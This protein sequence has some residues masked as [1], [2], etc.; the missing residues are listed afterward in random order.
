MLKSPSHF[1]KVS[2]MYMSIA[3]NQHVRAA[4]LLKLAW[5]RRQCLYRVDTDAGQM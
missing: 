1:F 4:N 5:S 3:S 2:R